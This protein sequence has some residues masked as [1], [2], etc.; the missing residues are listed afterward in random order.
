MRHTGISLKKASSILILFL[1]VTFLN[2]SAAF[3]VCKNTPLNPVTDVAWNGIFP[4]R[5][6]GV[7]IASSSIDSP[8]DYIGSAVCVCPKTIG[9]KF[10]FWSPARLVETVKDPYC[11]TPLGV[12][13]SSHKQG[14][15][16]GTYG[17]KPSVPSTFQQSH[18][19]IFEVWH[20]LDMFYDFPCLDAEE[21]F[22]I[23]YM[24]EVD[25]LWQS[26]TLTLML[27]PEALL[28]ANPVAVLSCIPD[29]VASNLG[30][31]ISALFWC[32]GSWGNAYPLSGH[33]A[34]S[35]YTEGNAALAARM[36]FKLGREMLLWDTGLNACGKVP[37]P[38]WVKEN[39][40]LQIVKPVAASS[41]VPIGRSSIFWGQ[42][43]NPAFGAGGNSS[44][45]FLWVL[46][47]KVLCCVGYNF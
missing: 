4:I 29:T 11:F 47:R 40:R 38:I 21:S 35:D 45:N 43:K 30:Y 13:L 31:P 16:G 36:V 10:S 26:D 5:I 20:A 15:L 1:S 39:Y 6:G 32:M 22:D 27:N 3:A 37:T 24:T 14:F 8:P 46:F 18:W 9:L 34:E 44:D 41:P 7:G 28:F 33:A 17:E 25:P 19:Y 2:I 42:L 23:A 12:E